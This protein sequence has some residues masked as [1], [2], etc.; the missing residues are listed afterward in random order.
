MARSTALIN[1]HPDASQLERGGQEVALVLNQPPRRREYHSAA[2]ARRVARGR[3]DR[4]QLGQATTLERDA[5]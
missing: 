3:E 1:G 4:P 2:A 5:A